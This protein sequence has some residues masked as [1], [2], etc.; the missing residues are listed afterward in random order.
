MPS[1]LPPP[2][3]EVQAL[4][5]IVPKAGL[6]PLAL[7]VISLMALM[8]LT[9]VAIQLRG[10]PLA[11]WPKV[12]APL[13][14]S[15]SGPPP[16]GWLKALIAA[17]P[18]LGRVIL[19]ALILFETAPSAADLD[20]VPQSPS[21]Q[22]Q[23]LLAQD[24][25][26]SGLVA[27][28][29][30]GL[31]MPGPFGPLPAIAL[32][33]RTSALVYARPFVSNGRPRVAL[34]VGR[35]GLNAT[36]T[37]QAIEMLPPEVTLSFMPYAQGLLGWIDLARV[38]GHE[39]LI[40]VPME[41]ID[42]PANDP[43]PYTLLAQCKAQDRIKRLDWV[44]SRATGYFGVSNYLGSRCVNSQAAMEAFLASLK[45]HGLAFIDDG[46]AVQSQGGLPRGSADGVLDDQQLSPDAIDKQ[47]ASLEQTAKRRGQ[48]LGKGNA[49]PVTVAQVQQWAQGLGERGLQLAPASALMSQR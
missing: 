48:A 29:I 9:S 31:S 39:V 35:L 22:P 3:D 18:Q 1:Q 38:H 13:L 14:R 33:G 5:V 34:I 8:A 27:A 37:R 47:L 43:G 44:L 16:E 41:P 40:E 12:H 45:K 17:K 2:S 15:D 25:G 32:D 10:D 30:A 24:L 19:Q 36:L 11:G 21:P 49:Y 7:A 26:Q 28:P 23:A 42:Y 20:R 4:E 6:S 46:T